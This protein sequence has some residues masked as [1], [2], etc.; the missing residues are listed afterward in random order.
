MVHRISGVEY[1][2][3]RRSLKK[4][5][6]QLKQKYLKK[7]DNQLKLAI[8]MQQKNCSKGAAEYLLLAAEG[9]L[10]EIIDRSEE[11]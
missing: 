5:K 3:M 7:A 11:V 6:K 1:G 2:E 4:E 8:V 9:R 10:G